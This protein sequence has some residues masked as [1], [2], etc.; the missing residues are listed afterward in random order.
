M[1]NHYTA[2]NTASLTES[3]STHSD[4]PSSLQPIVDNVAKC[5]KII[6]PQANAALEV[7]DVN[8]DEND[9]PPASK[10]DDKTDLS[11]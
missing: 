5:V 1:V 6:L 4:V 11:I 7:I 3:T 10:Q 8:I 9:A 2:N